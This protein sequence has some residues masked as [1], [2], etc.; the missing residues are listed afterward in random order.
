[1]RRSYVNRTISIL[2]P[3]LLFALW[4]A[5]ARAQWI[6]VRFFSSPSKIFVE[7]WQMVES[8]ELWRHT[9]VS[10]VRILVG[11]AIGT[12]LGVVLGLAIGLVPTVSAIFKPLIDATFPIPKVGL[13]PLVI[14][15]FGLGEA[16]KYAIIAISAFYLIVINTAA[17]VRQIERI[18][19]D[20]GRNYHAGR[21]MM[22]TDVALPGALPLD[23]HRNEDQHG[24][25]A[26]HHRH[27]RVAGR[28]ERHRLPDLDELAGVRGGEDVRG[29][30][31]LGGARVPSRDD[32]RLGRAPAHTLGGHVKRE[33]PPA[34][35][36]A[37]HPV[38]DAG[39]QR[40]PVY[41]QLASLFRRFIVT[42]QWPVDRQVPTHETLAAQ[43]D[44]NPATV[45]K[46]IGLL[47]DEGL[48]QRFRRRGT[49]VVAKPSSA[50]AYRIPTTWE[51]LLLAADALE[52]E[53]LE[54]RAAKSIPAP[55][56]G[57]STPAAGYRYT[58]R[59]YRRGAQRIA[60]EAHL[61]RDLLAGRGTE[62][63]PLARLARAGVDRVDQTVRFG[64]ADRDV[65]SCLGIALND[66]IAVVHLSVAAKGVLRWASACSYR[67][68][69]VM[70]A[71][72]IRFP[73][74]A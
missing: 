71:E 74:G 37:A 68:D 72:P 27:G 12:A 13:L 18:Y 14:I 44:V 30:A 20:V 54:S 43:F 5:A 69:A 22:F 8:G 62:R 41:V 28:E 49:F 67:G 11:F 55:F 21:L 24:R 9:W 56:H 2:T 59:L 15:L 34:V 45:R 46:A 19:L 23:P 40:A 64:I 57:G 70:L 35:I 52:A 50:Q 10:M 66:P 31:G 25:I 1:M 16:S 53:V 33:A 17:G 60:V 7:L 61:D 32:P 47:E 51:D 4:E 26:D 3:I 39:R 73:A 36:P 58:R 42:G 29:P 38:L 48:A 6:D 65:A 63:Q